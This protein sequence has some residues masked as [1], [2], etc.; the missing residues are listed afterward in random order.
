MRRPAILDTLSTTT[1]ANLTADALSGLTVAMVAIPLSLAIAIASGADP[2]TGLI[3]AIVAGF[4]ISAVGG[5]HFQIAGAT[6]HLINDGV[7]DTNTGQVTLR[8]EGEVCL[9]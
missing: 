1:R 4:L 7:V 8:Y 6:G 2:T 5:S 3:T 9:P